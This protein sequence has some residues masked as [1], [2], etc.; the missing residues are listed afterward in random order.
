MS[1]IS[2]L[3]LNLDDKCEPNQKWHLYVSLFAQTIIEIK[4]EGKTAEDL[5]IT[6]FRKYPSLQLKL[7]MAEVVGLGL[8]EIG[9]AIKNNVGESKVNNLIKEISWDAIFEIVYKEST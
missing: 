3:D 4:N 8:Q 7:W 2:I 5:W 9:D 6:E 1:D